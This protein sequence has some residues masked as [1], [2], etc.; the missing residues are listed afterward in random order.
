MSTE[1]ETAGSAR[2]AL[3]VAEFRRLFLASFASNVGRWMQFAALGVLGWQ[4]TGSS[5][6]LGQL[7]F[8]QLV[9]LG[10]LSLLGGSLADTVDRRL[11]LAA[12]QAWQMGWTAVLAVLVI[13]D[14]IGPNTLTALVFVIGLG[15][16]LFAPAFTS[17][18]PLIAG[19]DN[20][21]AAISLNS[22]QSNGARVVGPAVGGFLTSRF[23]FAEVFAFNAVTYV[24][25][26]AVL[27]GLSFPASTARPASFRQ[28]ILGGFDVVRRAPQVGRPITLMA[29]FALCCMPFIGQLPA[30]A[31]VNLGIDGRS[32]TYGWFYATFGLGALVGAAMV[33]TVLLRVDKPRLVRICLVGFAVALAALSAARSLTVAFPAVFAVA[34]FYLVMPT[35]LATR[36]QQHVDSSI[37]GRV[38]A[39]WVLSF[40]GMVP[41]ANL[42]AGR[43]VE[44]TS[45]DTVL[46]AGAVAAVVLAAI[47]RLPGGPVVG[48]R[49]LVEP[50]PEV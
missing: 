28:R 9:P 19:E 8:A 40:G 23:G 30:I 22:V 37:R 36:W 10:F 34:V 25:I 5:A 27:I 11:L 1:T 13:D 46:L 32:T 6:F 14:V 18:L 15:Q 45:L 35:S 21:Q 24:L 39:M 4:L 48:E 16:G 44:A 17:V 7:I 42:I 50:G 3:A 2:D 29:V 47:A 31:E 49:I 33:G 20:I 41:I 26:I 12:T 43:I 38:A